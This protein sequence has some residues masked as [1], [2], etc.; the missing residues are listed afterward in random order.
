ML[1]VESAQ[2]APFASR[3]DHLERLVT[4]AEELGDHGSERGWRSLSFTAPVETAAFASWTRRRSPSATSNLTYRRETCCFTAAS[5]TTSSAAIARIDAGS[6][7]AP[8]VSRGWHRARNAPRA[9]ESLK[10]RVH[11]GDAV[12]VHN[13]SFDSWVSDRHSLGVERLKLAP[14]AARHFDVAAHHEP[15]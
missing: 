14:A 2:H 3:T 5:E 10:H 4:V 1:P 9:A 12:S 15:P 8:P 11:T 6:A 13:T 7:N